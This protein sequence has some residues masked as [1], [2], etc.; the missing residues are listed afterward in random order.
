MKFKTRTE[1][2]LSVGLTPL[3][4]II[5]I[6]LIFFMVTTTFDRNSELKIDLPEAQTE[7]ASSDEKSLE[8]AIDVQGNYFVNRVKVVST[9]PK[10][11]LLAISKVVG[12]DKTIPVVIKADANT[13]HQAVVTAMDTVGRLGLRRMSIATSFSE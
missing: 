8:V 6:L 1:E 4:D 11:L 9:Q 12:E 5:F 3:I 2:E 10:A 7:T 13:P